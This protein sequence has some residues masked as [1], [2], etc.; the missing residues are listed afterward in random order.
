MKK[1]YIKF[2][3]SKI[4]M[5]IN[6]IIDKNN[7]L[8]AE[9]SISNEEKEM[10]KEEQSLSKEEQLVKD[11]DINNDER[12]EN[13]KEDK[14]LKDDE[15]VE[16]EEDDEEEVEEEVEDDEEV[17][18][19]EEVVDDEEVENGEEKKEVEDDEEEEE[20]EEESLVSEDNNYLLGGGYKH[21]LQI[22]IEIISD[23]P[24]IN[25]ERIKNKVELYLNNYYSK[26]YTKYPNN[27]ELFYKKIKKN[28]YLKHDKN[29]I[30]LIKNN[31]DKKQIILDKI[32]KPQYL[33]ISKR[34]IEL[35][36]E[37]K[38][39]HSKLVSMFNYLKGIVISN[40]EEIKK[41]KKEKSNYI[42]LLEE[43]EI[44]DLYFA[45]INKID[46]NEEKTN[47]IYQ[48]KHLKYLN[49]KDI[50]LESNMYKIP[51]ETVMNINTI[52]SERLNQYN[53]LMIN[54]KKGKVDKNIKEKIIEYLSNNELKNIISKTNNEKKNQDNYIDYIVIET[55]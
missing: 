39:Y 51:D 38:S 30:Y 24:L 36:S 52:Q 1:K 28:E 10:K 26:E 42:S 14:E 44:I 53:D 12:V 23:N 40:P 25:S 19:E 35:Q 45:T 20:E 34:R 2:I 49:S 7:Q 6:N 17:E 46:V 8:H 15:E 43:R 9:Q 21:D 55:P 16:D 54:L 48:N 32:K 37:I 3:N 4:K 31:K 18:E 29:F 33:H 41:F 22:P 11:E 27:L 5:E 50:I 47:V 13:S